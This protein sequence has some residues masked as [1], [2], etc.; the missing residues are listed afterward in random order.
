MLY[1]WTSSFSPQ[2]LFEQGYSFSEVLEMYLNKKLPFG[3]DCFNLRMTEEEAIK[4]GGINVTREF[5]Q[6]KTEDIFSVL[7]GFGLEIEDKF[8][9]ILCDYDYNAKTIYF[10]KELDDPFEYRVKVTSYFFK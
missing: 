9:R 1:G 5:S 8:M 10:V 2:G 4:K 6:S 7:G 3:D